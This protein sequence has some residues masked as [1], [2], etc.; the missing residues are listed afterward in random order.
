M[1][2]LRVLLVLVDLDNLAF[3]HGEADTSCLKQRWRNIIKNSKTLSKSTSIIAAATTHTIDA[4]NRLSSTLVSKITESSTLIVLSDASKNA[5]DF[6]LVK[7]FM[8]K[9]EEAV[10]RAEGGGI[11]MVTRDVRLGQLMTYMARPDC[12]LSFWS[13]PRDACDV[14][15]Y[16]P[17][18]FVISFLTRHDLDRF[19]R[20]RD[21]FFRSQ[22][23]QNQREKREQREQQ[24]ERVPKERDA[25]T[26]FV[27]LRERLKREHRGPV[28]P[29]ANARHKR[30]TLSKTKRT[31]NTNMN[32]ALTVVDLDA[33]LEHYST[34]S[35]FSSSAC[36]QGWLKETVEESPNPHNLI[37]C[38]SRKSMDHIESIA[39]ADAS[40]IK[41]LASRLHVV[42]PSPK[43]KG[44]GKV[45]E[46][47]RPTEVAMLNIVTRE[48]PGKRR[49]HIVIRH[50]VLLLRVFMYCMNREDEKDVSFS[51]LTAASCRTIPAYHN[52]WMEFA[53]REE[54][55][56]FW[57]ALDEFW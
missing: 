7:I 3:R 29:N 36:L 46:H 43:D 12:R 41:T 4:I 28:K 49:I 8:E 32:I 35:P 13:S 20:M 27:S 31:S 30:Q 10:Y 34:P 53:D 1:S 56:T 33:L 17:G 47:L 14:E 9:Q 22:Q 37:V 24:K 21:Q 52:R 15:I 38:C 54:L 5:V 44:G 42:E 39:P 6:E 16:G 19:R 55:D 23:Q 48:A 26:E 40:R 45:M 2:K 57:A 25:A 50:S 51:Y 11:H 18:R